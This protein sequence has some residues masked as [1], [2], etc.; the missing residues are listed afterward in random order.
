MEAC[1]KSSFSISARPDTL[2]KCGAPFAARRLLFSVGGG[3]FKC[4]KEV[5]GEMT[6]GRIFERRVV[7]C[8]DF[9]E[10]G[11][12]LCSLGEG[13]GLHVAFL[14]VWRRM[15]ASRA[16]WHLNTLLSAIGYAF[17]QLVFGPNPADLFGRGDDDEDFLFFRRPDCRGRLPDNGSCALW[18]R[19]AL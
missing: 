3:A 18:R 11:R 8:S 4:R 17:Y 9:R 2:K 6:F 12:V 10:R 5:N 7:F 14:I 16:R 15:V 19:G 1:P 13:M